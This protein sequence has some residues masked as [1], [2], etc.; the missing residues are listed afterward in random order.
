MWIKIILNIKIKL[1]VKSKSG[2]NKSCRSRF[3]DSKTLEFAFFRFFY[4]LLLN[5]KICSLM[6]MSILQF[7]P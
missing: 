1:L 6:F 5:F 2:C 3:K 4:E 7:K